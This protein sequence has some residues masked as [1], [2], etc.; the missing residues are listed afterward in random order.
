MQQDIKKL[1]MEF[2]KKHDLTD[3]IL[4]GKDAHIERVSFK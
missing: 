2:H 4:L 3:I 1:V